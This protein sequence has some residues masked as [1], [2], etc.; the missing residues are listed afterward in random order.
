MILKMN[1]RKIIVITAIMIIVLISIGLVASLF[2]GEFSI[3]LSKIKK[4]DEK[5][6][7]SIKD[8]PINFSK[9]EES[10]LSVNDL[11]FMSSELKNIQ[12]KAKNSALLSYIEFRTDLLE[13][14]MN[15]KLALELGEQGNTKDGFGCKD[16]PYIISAASYKNQSAHAGYKAVSKLQEFFKTY[17][18]EADLTEI[19]KSFPLFLNVSLQ[20]IEK[21]SNSTIKFINRVCPDN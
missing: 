8:Y 20:E 15:Y 18:Q 11:S 1:Q 3:G 13:A 19:P 4:I 7:Y 5:Y 17:P 2:L 9:I 14:E 10:Q 21:K 12:I 16:K 6:N